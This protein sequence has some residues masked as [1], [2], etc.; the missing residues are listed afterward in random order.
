LAR[1]VSYFKEVWAETFP[2][3]SQNLGSRR[4]RRRQQAKMQ[5]EEDERIAAMTP[6]E[7]EEMEK[8]IPEWKRNA[9]VTTD[10]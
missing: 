8:S 9:L 3:H 10:T 7:I 2:D 6:E 1:G 5:R 4:D